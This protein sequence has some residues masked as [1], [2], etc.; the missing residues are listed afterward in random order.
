MT[1]SE[2]SASTESEFT[3]PAAQGQYLTDLDT[4]T[5]SGGVDAGAADINGRGFAR[6]VT[7]SANAAGPVSFAEY[8]LGRQWRTFSATVGLRDDSPTGGS[9]TFEVV[10]DGSKKYGKGIPLGESQEVKVD[11]T[12]A[13][14]MKLIITYAGQEAGSYYYGSWGDAKLK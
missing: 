6:S 3:D 12:H 5:S 10:V 11:V 13:L 2:P 1:E 14:R 7:L 8:N 9:L 4:L